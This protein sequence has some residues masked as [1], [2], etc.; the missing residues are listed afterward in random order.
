[1]TQERTGASRMARNTGVG[2]KNGSAEPFWGTLAM[3]EPLCGGTVSSE[4]MSSALQAYIQVSRMAHQSAHW[5]KKWLRRAILK[6]MLLR[7]KCSIRY[8]SGV[9]E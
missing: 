5:S 1:M 6:R 9:F 3:R 7:Y 4:C 2:L 8:F